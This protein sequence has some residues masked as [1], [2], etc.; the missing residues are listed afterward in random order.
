MATSGITLWSQTRDQIINGALRKCQV[1]QEGQTATAAQITD[2]AEALNN[3]VVEF[4]TLGMPLWKRTD[5]DVT[6]VD[7]QQDYVIGVAETLAYA[8]PLKLLQARLLQPQSNT[9]VNLNILADYDF[10]RLSRNSAGVPV[11]VAYK[12]QLDKGTL[13]VW[14]IPNSA[15]PAGT[16]IVLTYTSP[17]EIFN[18]SSDD[19]DFPGEWYN[20]LIYGLASLMSDEFALPIPDKQWIEKQSEKHLASALSIGLE[21]GSMFFQP[22]NRR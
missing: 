6:M 8:Y 11:S 10:N 20:A 12:P 22:D 13:S 19:A 17:V 4:R 3:L 14:P 2:A 21:D 16:K 18:A 1:L 5:L 15:V 9:Y 7:S